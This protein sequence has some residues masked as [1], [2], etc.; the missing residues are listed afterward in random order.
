V[1]LRNVNRDP[2]DRCGQLTDEQWNA[3]RR[4]SRRP[5]FIR[6]LRAQSRSLAD[7]CGGKPTHR[8]TAGRSKNG[9]GR[10]G[11]PNEIV[12]GIRRGSRTK[13]SPHPYFECAAAS[14]A[15]SRSEAPALGPLMDCS[16]RRAGAS[17]S[18]TSHSRPLATDWRFDAEIQSGVGCGTG[19]AF[20]DLRFEN[21]AVSVDPA[22]A[23]VEAVPLV[24]TC[25]TS[26]KYPVPTNCWCFTAS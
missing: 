21:C 5:H 17:R 16:S 4:E 23:F 8:S 15:T 1:V 6:A 2:A 13:R 14:G 18:S 3:V 11:E 10:K 24:I 7:L 9:T 20:R 25:C 19:A 12:Q 26:S 22:S